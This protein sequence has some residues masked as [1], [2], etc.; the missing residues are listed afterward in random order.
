VRTRSTPGPD[1]WLLDYSAVSDS[2][3]KFAIANIEPG[4]YRLRG[5]RNGFLTLEYGAHGSQTAG[6]ML[7][8]EHPQQMKDIELRLTPYGV[9]TG[10]ILDAD[11]EA[12]EGAQVQLLRS[13]YING[14]KVLATTGEVYT[15]DLGEY[16]KYGLSPGKY[17]VYA[18]DFEG[19]PTL[20]TDK[21]QYVPVYYPGVIDPAGAIPIDV[22]AG[23]QTSAGNMMLRKAPTVT[24]KGKVVVELTETTGPPEV[25]MGLRIGHD[26]RKVGQ[27]RSMQAKVSTSGEFEVRG[28]TPGSYSAMAAVGKA[29]IWRTSPTINVEVGATNLEGLL[30]TI[31]DYF[32]G[33]GAD[34]GG[35]RCPA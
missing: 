26:T 24:V 6:A 33:A 16:R 8:L 18:E 4:K 30:L 3:G 34:S 23:V 9:L 17:Y 32:F 22:A 11:G 13:R 1:D 21:E 27:F 12:V 7:D 20:S 5:S 29:G 35:G 10:R 31:G 2:A 15:N 14:K 25:N 19:A 28:L